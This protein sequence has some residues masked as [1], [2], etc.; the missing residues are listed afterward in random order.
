MILRKCAEEILKIVQITK[1]EISQSKEI[2]AGGVY[3][4][5]GE[6]DTIRLFSKA[7]RRLV[8]FGVIYSPADT[9]VYHSIK[10]PICGT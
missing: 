2:I 1:N 5:A 6:S 9:F 10:I 3:I 7:V 8:D 4:G